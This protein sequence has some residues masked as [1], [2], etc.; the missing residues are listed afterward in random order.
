M[1]E[2]K[3]ASPITLVPIQPIRPLP[4]ASTTMTSNGGGIPLLT[5]K[6]EEQLEK[7]HKKYLDFP[8]DLTKTKQENANQPDVKGDGGQLIYDQIIN[9]RYIF[10]TLFFLQSPNSIPSHDQ[11]MLLESNQNC[12]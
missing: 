4:L 9:A 7:G 11:D 12:F 8:T 2:Y 3:N 10:V 6:M 5:K 1:K